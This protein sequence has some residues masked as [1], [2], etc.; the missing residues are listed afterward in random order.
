MSYETE[1]YAKILNTSLLRH[2]VHAHAEE[3]FCIY[4]FKLS[5]KDKNKMYAH[6]V[7]S[8]HYGVQY[9]LGLWINQ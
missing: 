2:F 7:E 6:P 4:I 1:N 8:I 3:L 9:L 5:S